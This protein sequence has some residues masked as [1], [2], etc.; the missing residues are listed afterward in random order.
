LAKLAQSH[1]NNVRPLL[2]RYFSDFEKVFAR[3]VTDVELL[4][5]CDHFE[6]AGVRGLA[7]HAIFSSFKI[8]QQ[9]FKDC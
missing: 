7:P 1:Q 5:F 8:L 3:W 9:G 4:I 6:T 2:E